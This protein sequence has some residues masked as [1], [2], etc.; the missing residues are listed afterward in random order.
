MRV[1]H[2]I[3]PILGMIQGPPIP[4][5]NILIMDIDGGGYPL[6]HLRGQIVLRHIHALLDRWMW[7]GGPLLSPVLLGLLWPQPD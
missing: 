6:K 3:I 2:P 4:H 1:L 7:G 5:I